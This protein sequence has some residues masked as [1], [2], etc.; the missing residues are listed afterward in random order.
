MIRGSVALAVALALALAGPS[1][2]EAGQFY[3]AVAPS[4]GTVATCAPFTTVVQFTGGNHQT[5]AGVV[6]QWSTFAAP[7]QAN[8]QAMRVAMMRGTDPN[9]TVAGRTNL[10]TMVPGVINT[11]TTRVPVQAGDRVAVTASWGPCMFS[12]TTPSVH[13]CTS[14]NP[15]VG[16]MVI[17]DQTDLDRQVNAQ[18]YVELDGDSDGWGDESQDNCR[19]LANPAQ[20]NADADGSGDACDIDDDNDSTVDSEDAFPLDASESR[21]TD[22]DGVGDNADS[23]DDNDGVSDVDEAR[24][25]SDPKNASSRPA[26]PPASLVRADLALLPA[27]GTLKAPVLRAP[28]STTLAKLR[29]GIAVSAST[30]VPAR[31]D[32]ELRATPR[33]VRLA[34]FEALLASRS[35]AVGSGSRSVRLKPGKRWLARARRITLQLRV[36][37]TDLGGNRA[38]ATRTIKVR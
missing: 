16:E 27:E 24:A 15:D 35:L 33:G 3:G 30:G 26:G 17:A 2:A 14:C 23:D 8:P 19:G 1:E 4:V 13:Y 21:D 32:F 25:G 36:T 12:S 22:G 18:V 31:L 11:F 38:V 28:A 20:S 7:P 10:E 34:R 5:S 37:A 9:Y 6:T 29:K